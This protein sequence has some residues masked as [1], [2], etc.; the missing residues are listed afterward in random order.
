V[1]VAV[2]WLKLALCRLSTGTMNVSAVLGG[3]GLF[4]AVVFS[5]QVLMKLN[6]SPSFDAGAAKRQPI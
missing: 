5:A 6:K 3:A 4:I 1:K 2:I